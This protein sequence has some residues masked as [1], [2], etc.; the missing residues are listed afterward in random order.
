MAIKRSKK[1]N[2]GQGKCDVTP[3][4]NEGKQQELLLKEWGR[5]KS[6]RMSYYKEECEERSTLGLKY[7]K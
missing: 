2:H 3:M 7:N 1:K 6:G 4:P 5:N